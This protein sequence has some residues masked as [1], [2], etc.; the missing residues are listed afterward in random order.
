MAVEHKNYSYSFIQNIIKNRMTEYDGTV[1]DQVLPEHKNIRGKEYYDKQLTFNFTI[2]RLKS[3][4]LYF[5]SVM[6][7]LWALFLYF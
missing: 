6:P 4:F 2:N 5:L 7:I 1:P 3:G